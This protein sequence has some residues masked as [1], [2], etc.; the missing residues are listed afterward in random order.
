MHG[1][2]SRYHETTYS[3]FRESFIQYNVLCMLSVAIVFRIDF[4]LFH[5]I[6]PLHAIPFRSSRTKHYTCWLWIIYRK[7]I[8]K[9]GKQTFENRIELTKALSPFIVIRKILGNVAISPWEN[10][11]F[12]SILA[13]M[14]T[15]A[16]RKFKM[17]NCSHKCIKKGF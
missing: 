10:V 9:A 14:Q 13:C 8:R 15:K 2:T 6:T 3:A 5:C 11:R 12:R 4:A 16:L 7:M 17:L 1:S